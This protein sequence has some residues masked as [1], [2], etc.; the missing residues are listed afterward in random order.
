[1]SGHHPS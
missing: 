1:L